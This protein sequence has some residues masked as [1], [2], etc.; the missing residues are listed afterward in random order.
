[1]FREGHG[2]NI[3]INKYFSEKR[4]QIYQCSLK[5]KRAE[6]H[7]AAIYFPSILY[8]QSSNQFLISSFLW[9]MKLKFIHVESS[10]HVI[11]T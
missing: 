11:P 5:R 6:G 7:S 2:F 4:E 8:N 1:M 3:L 9:F 10:F